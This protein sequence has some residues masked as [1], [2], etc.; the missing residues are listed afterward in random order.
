MSDTYETFT[1]T[2]V[3][4]IIWPILFTIVLIK[5]SYKLIKEAL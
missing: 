3:T 5:T 4:G 1:E 2:A